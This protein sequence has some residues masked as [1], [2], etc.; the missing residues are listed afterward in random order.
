MTMAQQSPQTVPVQIHQSEE[1]I[2]LAAPM[3]GLEPPDI[4]VVIAGNKVTIHGQYR[5]S[6]QDEGDLL[7]EE[8]RQ[9]MQQSAGESERP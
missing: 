3:P 9:K 4:S 7:V 8:H 2:V 6:R 5:G 1:L